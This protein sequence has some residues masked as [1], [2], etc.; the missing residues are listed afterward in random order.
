MLLLTMRVIISQHQLLQTLCQL[1]LAACP[2]RLPWQSYKSQRQ[3]LLR[4]HTLL[5][6]NH[7]QRQ[8]MFVQDTIG[9]VEE[10]DID[11]FQ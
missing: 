10:P 6:S 11:A 2:S 1:T 7:L 5:L 3:V 8:D 9:Y 4:M